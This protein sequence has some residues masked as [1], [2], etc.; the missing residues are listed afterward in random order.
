MRLQYLADFDLR[1]PPGHGR[2]PRPGQMIY[3]SVFRTNGE[4]GYKPR[5][6]TVYIHPTL[7]SQ[8]WLDKRSQ[9]SRL[10][11]LPRYV[12]EYDLYDS[13]IEVVREVTN[14]HNSPSL[15]KLHE[16]LKSMISQSKSASLYVK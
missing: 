7:S 9:E 15:R 2:Y 12:V 5:A 3:S 1:R 16:K 14:A 13:V 4:R 10:G 8:I 6:S 11:D